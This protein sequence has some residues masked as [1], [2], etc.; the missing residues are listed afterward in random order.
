MEIPE[1]ASVSLS[2]AISALGGSPT[3]DVSVMRLSTLNIRA[4]AIIGLTFSAL[5]Q[6]NKKK[7]KDLIYIFLHIFTLK[8]VLVYIW[9]CSVSQISVIA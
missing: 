3:G 9:M 7:A 1:L 4:T 2:S 8:C 5:D 6:G